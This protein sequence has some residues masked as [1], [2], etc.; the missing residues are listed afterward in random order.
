MRHFLRFTAVALAAALCA[1][2]HAQSTINTAQ[3]AQNSTL[4]SLVIR[5]LAQA[6][7]SDIN[8]L[9]GMHPTASSCASTAT[10]GTD[11][12]IVGT[13]PYLWTKWTGNTGGWAHIGS[14]DPTTGAFSIALSSGNV[15]KADPITTAFS[16]GR[17]TI[18][19]GYNSSLAVAG[20]PGT[21]GLNLAHSNIF[22]AQQT[23][24]L[25]AAALPA[26]LTGMLLNLGG[27]DATAA[28]LQVN[29]FGAI[30]AVSG[31][32]Y[33]GTNALPTAVADGTELV[34]INAYAYN[35]AALV[36][37]IVSFRTYV[38]QS[39]GITAGAQGSRGCIAT[40]TAGGTTL[41]NGLCQ[42]NDRGVTLESPTSASLGAGWINV[43]G[44]FA[45]NGVAVTPG[46][47]GAAGTLLQGTGS[48]PSYTATPTLG[49]AGTTVGTLAFANL[50]T[51]SIKLQPQTGALGTSVLTLPAVTDTLAV[52]AAA[53]A[54]TNKSYNGLTITST[55][56]V[57]TLAAGKTLTDTSAI[58][59]SVLLGSAGGGFTA[60]AGGNCTNQFIRSLS[61]A[62]ALTCATVQNTDL[63]NS[64]ISGVALGG[65]LFGLTFGTHLTA[66]GS[67]Y[68]GS[69][70][71]TITSDATNA[72]TVST[73]VAR[74]GSGNF[75]AGTITASLTGHASSD[76]AL[77]GCTMA[78]NIAM[79]GNAI[80]GAAG[81][82]GTQLTSTIATGTPPLVVASTTN[83]P[84]L[85]ASS[86]GGATFA[87]PG[88]IGG[89]TPGAA[90]FTT[91]AISSLTNANVI[92]LANIVQDATAWSLLGNATSGA[93]NYAPFTVGSL[94]NKASPA[95]SD[96]VMIQ[97]AATGALLNAT[98]GQIFAAV[99]SGVTDIG[100]A[101]GSITLGNQLAISGGTLNVKSVAPATMSAAGNVPTT[102][103]NQTVSAAGATFYAIGVS[104]S[105]AT[106]CKITIL[107]A[108]PKTGTTGAKFI[109]F[110]SCTPGQTGTYVYPLDSIEVQFD[111]SAWAATRCPGLWP[112]PSGV[113]VLNVN[114]SSGSDTWGASDGLSTGSR[115]FA[116][117]A[118]AG[119]QVI[120][121]MRMTP[122]QP[123]TTLNIKLCSGCTDSAL[124]HWSWQGGI[125][126]AT[127]RAAV[128]IDCNAGTIAGQ[129]QLFF[130]ATIVEVQQC[131][132]INTISLSEGA[133]F[134]LN[135]GGVL[136][137]PQMTPV[138]GGYNVVCSQGSKFFNNTGSGQV[139]LL[140]GS[141]AGL[142]V[143]S[144]GC[145]AQFP[146]NFQ[147]T[148][149]ITFSDTIA[150][151]QSNSFITFAGWSPNSFSMSASKYQLIECGIIEGSASLP[152]SA[153]SASCTQVN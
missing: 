145:T 58:G 56:G 42:H 49:I 134:I 32:V 149:N 92:T 128:V 125:V 48:A 19:L 144:G 107:N 124:I 68:N 69:A 113:F 46:S 95:T 88:T 106:G 89:G 9:L 24:N 120:G 30:A 116:S 12:L 129:I 33:G 96:K 77:T 73:I 34:G 138:S 119:A 62:A 3:P 27:V 54:L 132:L 112:M 139:N 51:G 127:G 63:A 60:Y 109:S 31:A 11:C 152:G 151:A 110:V 72:N 136:S 81:I 93:A 130:P 61:A 84:N 118:N 38:E 66:G 47:P 2:A 141:G 29:S 122:Q 21:L 57:L 45:I 16:N 140:G 83:V 22:N 117:T 104:G 8:G 7:A 15:L 115:A 153:G 17:V 123:P 70:A 18:G 43:T 35:G 142:I 25:N 52:L 55:T 85:N 13:S 26:A 98:I 87:A 65:N 36:G 126:G 80:T 102:A 71:V 23:V 20:S 44:G 5:Q 143:A 67:S 64:T 100:G 111:G 150:R 28:R 105:Y 78:G 135:G 99:G 79:G 39:G 40:T 103:C 94:T 41:T 53:Q 4:S 10:V 6:A 74:D 114:P 97:D 59:A 108:D 75:S 147:Q 146:S 1:S 90:T 86:L 121:L 37:P 148:G 133:E 82:T 50:S 101:T 76:C 137:A 131:N 91:L 14:I